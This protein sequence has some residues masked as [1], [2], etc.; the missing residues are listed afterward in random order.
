MSL[1]KNSASRNVTMS[2]LYETV[3][4]QIV[5]QEKKQFQKS[6]SRLANVTDSDVV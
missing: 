1:L 6:V 5:Y 3:L 4:E 2:N